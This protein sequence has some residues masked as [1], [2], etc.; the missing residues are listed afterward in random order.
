[1][2][3]ESR[4]D[5]GKRALHLWK[6]EGEEE[7]VSIKEAESKRAEERSNAIKERSKNGERSQSVPFTRE[8]TASAKP[9]DK[10]QDPEKAANTQQ[11]AGGEGAPGNENAPPQKPS[12]SKLTQD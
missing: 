8:D 1:L 2:G 3:H 5:E 12:K 4:E 7:A 11:Q 6:P 9:D 10:S